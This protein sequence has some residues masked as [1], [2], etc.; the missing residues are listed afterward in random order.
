M[1]A[2]LSLAAIMCGDAKAS[3]IVTLA[4]TR[5]EENAARELFHPDV[6]GMVREEIGS[7]HL[8]LPT[9]FGPPK[10]RVFGLGHDNGLVTPSG[11]C[12]ALGTL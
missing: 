10:R 7:V 11:E 5:R 9:N 4:S 2:A 6:E 8:A 12:S 3:G 1:K